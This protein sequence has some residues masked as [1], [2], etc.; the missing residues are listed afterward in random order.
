M[1]RAGTRPEIGDTNRNIDTPLLRAVARV[2]EKITL[3]IELNLLSYVANF[4]DDLLRRWER[5]F[6]D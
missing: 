3:F 2:L 5:R 1:I 4:D 6:L